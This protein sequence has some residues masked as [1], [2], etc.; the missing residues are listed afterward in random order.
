[1]RPD[2]FKKLMQKKN[3]PHKY[4]VT[5]RH[6]RTWSGIWHGEKINIVFDS[7]AEMI[8]F[9]ELRILEMGG[10]IKNLEIQK[11]F[12]IIPPQRGERPAFYTPDFCYEMNGKKHAEEV[13][14]NGTKN[15]DDY[16]LRRK[17]FK[18]RYPEIVFIESVR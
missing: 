10:T 12:E 1:M 11:E 14:S 15:R 4:G 9:L 5:P 2:E 8:R 17:L 13:K 7:K 6:E 16:I 3:K 18:L